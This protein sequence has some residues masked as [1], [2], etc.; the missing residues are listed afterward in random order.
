M[1]LATMTDAVREY[2]RNVGAD[3]ADQQWI[4]S[5]YDSWEKN[6]FYTGPDQGHPEDDRFE[7]DPEFADKAMVI[8]TGPT[9]EDDYIPF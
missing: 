4:L 6:P 8:E 3:Q 7:D 2:A 1:T 5:P 9:L